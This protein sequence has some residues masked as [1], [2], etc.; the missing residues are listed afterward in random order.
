MT[1]ERIRSSNEIKNW[2]Q[3]R[4]RSLNRV[5]Q[6]LSDMACERNE[7]MRNVYPLL[8]DY[9]REKHGMEFQVKR[10][11]FLSLVVAILQC[12]C[13]LFVKVIDMRWG[14]RSER[15]LDHKGPLLCYQEIINCQSISMGPSFIVR[16]FLSLNRSERRMKAN[17]SFLTGDAWPAIRWSS[18]ASFY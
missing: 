8:K 16:V 10:C 12:M 5:L 3:K 6:F 13:P 9:C 1:Y 2:H 18:P 17:S 4:K 15:Q 7:L 14:V 11:S